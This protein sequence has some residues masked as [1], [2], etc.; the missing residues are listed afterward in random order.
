MNYH[1]LVA[2]RFLVRTV[3]QAIAALRMAGYVTTAGA[4]EVALADVQEHFQ[5]VA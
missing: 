3:I 1:Q 4:L 2:L 5:E